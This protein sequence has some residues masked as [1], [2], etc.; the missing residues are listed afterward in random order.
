MNSSV[1]IIQGFSARLQSDFVEQ[2]R[3]G[4]GVDQAKPDSSQQYPAKGKEAVGSN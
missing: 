2:N 1:V 3:W 4:S